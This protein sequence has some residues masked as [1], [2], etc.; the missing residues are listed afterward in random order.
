MAVDFVERPRHG[1]CAPVQ[2]AQRLDRQ[3]AVDRQVP[4]D[5]G[6]AA[7]VER[8]VAEDNIVRVD[9]RIVT[10][11][12]HA[13]AAHVDLAGHVREVAAHL[14]VLGHRQRAARL[15]DRNMVQLARTADRLVA[16]PVQ[17][18]R[19]RAADVGVFGGHVAR[20]VQIAPVQIAQRL[21]R[22]VAVDRQV[23]VDHGRA[24]RVERHVAEDNIVRVDPR[25]VTLE[26]HAHAAHVDLAGHVR[27]V[28]AHLQVLGHRQRAARLVDR[29]IVQGGRTRIQCLVATPLEFDAARIVSQRAAADDQI[30]GHHQIV[31]IQIQR[32]R[33]ENQIAIDRQIVTERQRSRVP[34]IQVKSP[35]AIVIAK[36]QFRVVPRSGI[37]Y[38]RMLPVGQLVIRPILRI[39]E[40]VRVSFAIPCDGWIASRLDALDV[41]IVDGKRFIST[42]VDG[43]RRTI[44]RNFVVCVF[45]QIDAVD[46]VAPIHR[47]DVTVPGSRHTKQ[48]VLVSTFH[49][50]I[51]AAT[52][53]EILPGAALQVVVSLPTEEFVIAPVPQ[54]KIIPQIAKQLVVAVQP[55]GR[56]IL[57]IALEQVVARC[58]VVRFLAR[59]RLD[60]CGGQKN[61]GFQ[62]VDFEFRAFH[63]D[64]V[65]VSRL[66]I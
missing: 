48:I 38:E 22:Q 30:A 60:P 56:I 12:L 66:L 25:I 4:V 65:I 31:A 17:N 11:E 28:A 13:H 3:V 27:E 52:H 26:L 46:P 23:P 5:H 55:K 57:G 1:D 9:P 61:P 45:G 39:R 59:V 24:A 32:T 21:D 19:G 15:V 54:E 34:I 47:D 41:R 29:D 14:Q 49:G 16:R 6:R 51:A 42:Q 10:L 35:D 62:R 64:V 8:H 33:I 58:C 63:V 18:N 43:N 37:K 36:V 20:H 53:Q 7:R 44:V 50:V 2:I 40:V